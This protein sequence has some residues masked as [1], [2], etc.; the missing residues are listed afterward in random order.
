MPRGRFTWTPEEEAI[1]REAYERAGAGN[2]G[3]AA[4]AARLGRLQSN[5]SRKARTMGLTRKARPQPPEAR[6]AISER[7]KA[8]LAVH[9]ERWLNTKGVSPSPETREKLRAAAQRNVAAGTHPG[10][11]PRS[12]ETRA[13][14]SANMTRRLMA[15]GNVYSRARRG[16]RDDLGDRFFRSSW[17]ANY[18]RFLEWQRQ[19]GLI[20][21]WEYEPETF[22]FENIRRGVRSYLPD[23]RVTESD[24]RRYY[25]EV[26]GWMDAKSKT[27]LARMR[28][29][30]PD[31]ELRVVDAKTYQSIARQLAAVIPGWEKA[32]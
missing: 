27:K 1:L 16:R 17:E 23:F 8:H 32:A 7:A 9:P 21:A 12:D 22:W 15:G 31:V 25:V 24:G 30:Y 28:K 19:R 5:V 14:Q 10:L 2:V 6:R 13:K 26:K 11:R 20:A 18:A 29:Y 3:L 4:L